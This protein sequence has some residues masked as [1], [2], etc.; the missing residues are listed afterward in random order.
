MSSFSKNSN[1]SWL[2]A[3]FVSLY[4][5]GSW[6]V[7]NGLWVELPLLVNVL[8]EGWNLPAYLIIIIQVS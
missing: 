1:I 3:C 4:G 6:I 7:V 5:L 2:C 8:P